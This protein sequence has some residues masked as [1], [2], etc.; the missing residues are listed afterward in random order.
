M[1]SSCKSTL[2]RI[3]QQCKHRNLTP[4]PQ[5]EETKQQHTARIKDLKQQLMEANKDRTALK[6][7]LAEATRR[8]ASRA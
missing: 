5:I 8:L 2:F 1:P 6:R 4:A 7:D 3:V